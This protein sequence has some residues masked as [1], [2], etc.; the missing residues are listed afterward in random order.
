MG[1]LDSI[2][3]MFGA[4]DAYSDYAKALRG[5]SGD[6]P[7]YAEKA[8]GFISPWQQT[9]SQSLKD[10]YSSLMGMQDPTQYYSKVMSGYQM[11]PAA[12]QQLK[13][14]QESIS[15]SAASRGLL[16]STAQGQNLMNYSQG[17]TSQDMRN[18]FGDI[19]GIGG[20]YRQGMG[21]ISR[22]GLT[23]G[24]TMGDQEMQLAKLIAEL[25]GNAA[26]AEASGTMAN[27]KFGGGLL[28]ALGGA[29]GF[30]GSG[31]F[32]EKLGDKFGGGL[33]KMFGL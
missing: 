32:L 2:G 26:G 31:G 25:R 21:D 5:I 33:S 29:M 20:Q 14:G 24:T 16:G 28:G 23:A 9:G 6:M 11:S 10:L 8:Q 3:N 27:Q 12:Q 19:M 30:G 22:E 4:G 17:L 15:S 18:Y 1:F 13:S 7:Q